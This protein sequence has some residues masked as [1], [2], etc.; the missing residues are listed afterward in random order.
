MELSKHPSFNEA[1]RFWMLLGWIS[2]GGPTGQISIMFTEL[3]EKRR[4]ISE[5]RFL[6]A[7]NFCMFL[8]GPE[9]IQLAIYIGWLLHGIRGGLA[10]GIFFV[11]PSIFILLALSYIYVTFSTVP[12]IASIFYGLKP[13]VLAIVLFA[14]LRIGSRVLKN[15]VLW[16][17]ALLAFIFIFFFEMPF[18]LI[19]FTSALIGWLGGLY[20]EK[21]FSAMD[22][23]ASDSLS[24]I[25]DKL[26]TPPHAKPSLRKALTTSILF[27]SLWWIPVFAM[28]YWRGWNSV[29]FQ[30][31]LFFSKAA[32]VTIGG[33]Y[34]VLSYVAQQSV[35]YFHWLSP[36]QMIDGLGLAETTPGPLIIVVQF[37]GFLGG[38][39]QPEGLNPLLSA[40]LGAFITSWTTFVPCFFLIFLGAPYIEMYRGHKKLITTLTAVTAAVVGVIFN[41][42]V[43]FGLQIL[44]PIQGFQWFALLIS[45]AAFLGMWKGNWG[46]VPIILGSGL[47]GIIYY[48]LSL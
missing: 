29:H 27:L 48:L 24:V 46:I 35:E 36:G 15:K 3:V 25:H 45:S 19:I 26:E 44:F 21:T 9:A 14:G 41:L 43:W 5:N 13:A 47:V 33:A 20:W 22:Q 18:P 32:M 11:L 1:L 42:A 6:H 23:T 37:V 10:A 12:F 4:W 17:I 34:S 2:F 31:G 40:V 8:P 28:G 38:W 16:S 7:L 30:E 39:N